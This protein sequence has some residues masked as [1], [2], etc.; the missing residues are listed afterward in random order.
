MDS[1]CEDRWTRPGTGPEHVNPFT[2]L[3][4]NRPSQPRSAAAES[5]PDFIDSA[6]FKLLM[7]SSLLARPFTEHVGPEN[8]LTL[9]EWRALIALN[10]K[11]QSSNTEISEL[12]GLDAMTISRAL[13][14]LHRRA[15]IERIRDPQDGRR[16]LNRLTASGRST[17]RS[18]LKGARLRQ[19]AMTEDWQADEI[20][21]FE[22][23][24]DRIIAHLREIG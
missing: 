10:A 23:A 21:T 22:T 5:E 6:I 1:A 17:Y 20:R 14:R 18:V 19:Q 2:R 15:R 9:P 4:M 7:V 13:D 3:N 24:L 8:D 11:G 16:Q 12:T